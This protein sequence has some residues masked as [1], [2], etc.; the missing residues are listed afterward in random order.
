M[1]FCQTLRQ[2][3]TNAEKLEHNV[4]LAGYQ[5]NKELKVIESL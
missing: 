4:T 1:N 2:T 3:Y 5:E